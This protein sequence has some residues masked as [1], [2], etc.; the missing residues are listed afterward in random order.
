MNRVMTI[1]MVAGMSI[2]CDQ[3]VTVIGAPEGGGGAGAA[4]PTAT[5]TDFDEACTAFCAENA[6][7]CDLWRG[8]CQT[9]CDSIWLDHCASEATA[10][11]QCLDA[12]PPEACRLSTSPCEPELDALG[13]CSGYDHCDPGAFILEPGVCSSSGLCDRTLLYQDCYATDETHFQCDCYIGTELA[14]T[15]E[16]T[17]IGCKF[18]ACCWNVP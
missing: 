5:R 17:D 6:A 1:A 3:T 12:Q 9:H 7:S 4:L 11:I 8:F 15:C 2:A 14:K 10:L 18:E 13:R 16:T